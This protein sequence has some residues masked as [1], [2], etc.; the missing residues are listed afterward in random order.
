M[1]RPARFHRAKN[2]RP[3][4]SSK[5]LEGSGTGVAVPS[6]LNWES[7][8]RADAPSGLSRP[9]MANDAVPFRSTEKTCPSTSLKSPKNPDSCPE[10]G[11]VP[12]N[13][14]PVFGGRLST[15]PGF[16]NISCPVTNPVPNPGRWCGRNDPVVP[17]IQVKFWSSDSVQH[18]GTVTVR[19]QTE[20]LKHWVPP[21]KIP[22]KTTSTAKGVVGEVISKALDPS[23]W[24]A[25]PVIGIP[26]ARAGRLRNQAVSRRKQRR[27]TAPPGPRSEQS[28]RHAG[29]YSQNG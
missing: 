2:I 23:P 14:K 1:P 11:I 29:N 17:L 22:P 18:A 5:R 13:E 3:E 8:M 27:F 15:K 7:L 28:A 4:P 19:S 9:K 24:S 25:M 10:K 26:S 20:P 16:G 6:K 12:K 21:A